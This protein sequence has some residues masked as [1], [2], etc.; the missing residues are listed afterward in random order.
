M[1]RVPT[2]NAAEAA[3]DGR[4]PHER[5]DAVRA[6]ARGT[7]VA[8]AGGPGGHAVRPEPRQLVLAAEAGREGGENGLGR[9]HAGVR[10]RSDRR[11]GRAA[12]AGRE[13][14][15]R[16][17]GARRGR[18]TQS[19]PRGRV[20]PRADRLRAQATRGASRAR[21]AGARDELAPAT[22]PARAG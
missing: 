16:H 8:A 2:P 17:A 9:E 4:G 13:S 1:A 6:S 3:A 14:G 22:C 5:D 12:A 19:R 11:G 10:V 15:G 18:R 7:G 20:A 21:Q